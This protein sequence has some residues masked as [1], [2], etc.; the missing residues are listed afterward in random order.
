M[1]GGRITESPPTEQDFI[2]RFAEVWERPSPELLMV[3]LL[4]P[5]VWPG[6]LRYRADR[7]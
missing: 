2:R 1:N 5:R 6:F 7:G 3:V 4:H